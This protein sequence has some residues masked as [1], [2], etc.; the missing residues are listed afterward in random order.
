MAHTVSDE[1][2]R[3]EDALNAD[4][5]EAEERAGLLELEERQ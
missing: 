3:E 4:D 5:S 2:G 1:E